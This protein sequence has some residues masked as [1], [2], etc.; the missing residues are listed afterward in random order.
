MTWCG[1]LG[2]GCAGCALTL[3]C[4]GDWA[5]AG[6][7]GVAAAGTVAV[8]FCRQVAETAELLRAAALQ[9]V[10]SPE[11]ARERARIDAERPPW[12]TTPMPA[13]P[14]I[15]GPGMDGAAR[16]AAV[17][18]AFTRQTANQVTM[19]ALAQR[20]GPLY[21]PR[22]DG[23]AYWA[24]RADGTDIPAAA[25]NPDEL[26]MAIMAD[27]WRRGAGSSRPA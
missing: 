21:T 20:W 23:G 6:V 9:Q 19:A 27:W 18:A 13:V 22:F 24:Q 14:S 10:P 15:P 11:P 4:G 7:F 16:D 5:A 2:F 8:W 1:W 12:E 26:G 3:A 25:R 17:F